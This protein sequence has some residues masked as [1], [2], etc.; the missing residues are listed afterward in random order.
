MTITFEEFIKY[1][2]T[3]IIENRFYIVAKTNERFE[4]T[5][6]PDYYNREYSERC[7]FNLVLLTMEQIKYIISEFDNTDIDVKIQSNDITFLR[8]EN[9]GKPMSGSARIDE[10][11][12]FFTFKS[13]RS[14][15]FI[16]GIVAELILKENL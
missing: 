2:L 12:V 13:E 5:V 4:Y 15:N 1:N 9:C 11:V 14:K 8:P 10:N 6:Y 3:G 16:D 7:S